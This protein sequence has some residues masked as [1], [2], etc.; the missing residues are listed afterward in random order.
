MSPH[1]HFSPPDHQASLFQ[2][3][4][5]GRDLRITLRRGLLVAI[6][7]W[8][9]FRFVCL[10]VR[11]RGSSMEPTFQ[12]G[13]MHA[14]C[15]LQHLWRTPQRGDVVVISMS[16]TR[17]FYLKRILALPGERIAFS[18]GVLLIDGRKFEEAYIEEHGTWTMPE[19]TVPDGEY[20]VAGDNRA[21]PIERHTL[22][23]V[24]RSMIM[25]G[26]VF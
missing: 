9:F 18:N 7:A 16:G 25:G 19:M 22:G 14:A 24:N 4:L 11:V 21:I 12:N 15:L 20:F 8:L 1:L 6:A 13:E 2:R 5:V 26:V 17:A 23:T 10:P 3:I